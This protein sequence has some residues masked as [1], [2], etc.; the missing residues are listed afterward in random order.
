MYKAHYY[1]STKDLYNIIIIIIP[2]TMENMII[3][4]EHSL[5]NHGSHNHVT[6]YALNTL[7]LC[8]VTVRL[9]VQIKMVL[10]VSRLSMFFAEKPL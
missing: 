3:L 7:R 4:G 8:H 10:Y 1:T 6:P 5:L 2:V 9:Y